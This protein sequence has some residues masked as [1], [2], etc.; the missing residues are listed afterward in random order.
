MAASGTLEAMVQAMEATIG[1]HESNGNNTNYITSWYGM[2]GEPW[3]NMTVTYAAYHSGNAQNVCFGGKYAY[4]VAHAQAFKDRGLWHPMTNGVVGSGIRR[5][6]VIFFD[7]AG[8]SSIGGIDHVGLVTGVS[9]NTVL[10]IEGNISNRCDRFARHVDDIAGFGRPRYAA[11]SVGGGTSVPAPTTS[12][13]G[14]KYEPFPGSSFF[15]EGKRSP[16]IEAMH[17]RLVAEGCNKYESQSNKNVWGSGDKTSYAAFQRR[18]GFYGS[19]AN[20]VPGKSSWDQ[21]RVPNV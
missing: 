19:D 6:D 7:W 16:I 11:G 1:A 15:S 21:L 8:G 20:G 4:T 18:C 12:T 14:S 3:C 2:N 9:G 5:G 13:G 17:N 10:T